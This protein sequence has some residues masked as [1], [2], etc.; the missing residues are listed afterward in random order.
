MLELFTFNSYFVTRENI[1][2]T[3][4]SFVTNFII[5]DIKCSECLHERRIESFVMSTR[6]AF[7]HLKRIEDHGISS[8]I[9]QKEAHG[10]QLSYNGNSDS[11]LMLN[12]V[13]LFSSRV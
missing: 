10:I 1:G 12:V 13:L 5:T 11:S 4:C 7:T 8:T 2:Q 9:Q 3:L 6:N